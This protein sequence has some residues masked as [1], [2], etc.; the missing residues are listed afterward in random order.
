[1]FSEIVAFSAVLVVLV[2]STLVIQCGSKKGG[3]KKKGA[4][5]KAKKPASGKKPH[6]GSKVS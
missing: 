6:H 2:G 4:G 1:M 3:A 5:S